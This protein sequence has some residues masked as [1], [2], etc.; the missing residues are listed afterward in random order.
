MNNFLLPRFGNVPIDRIEYLDIETFKSDL[1]RKNKRTNNIL[2]P[3]RNVFKLALK[4]GFIEKNPVDLLDP[5][6]P[7]KPEINPFSFEEVMAIIED[8]DPHYRNF[9]MVVF[10][11]GMR[12]GEMAALKWENV[13]FKMGLIK[14]REALVRGEE[15]MPKTEG[16][17]RD[18]KMLLW[19]SSL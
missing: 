16:S 18:V 4:A 5:I 6:K 10:F 8:V 2:V 19:S 15:G 3:M 1:N 13:D 11:T 9:F 17:N 12:F 14:V 7:E